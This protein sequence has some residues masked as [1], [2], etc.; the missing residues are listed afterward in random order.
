MSGTASQQTRA[1]QAHSIQAL[2]CEWASRQPLATQPAL[3]NVQQKAR[4]QLQALAFPDRKTEAWKYTGLAA[5]DQSSLWQDPAPAASARHADSIAVAADSIKVESAARIALNNGKADISISA[6]AQASVTIQRFTDLSEA[7][8]QKYL[9][10]LALDPR[11]QAHPFAQLCEATLDQGWLVVVK[12]RQ[13]LPQ[14]IVIEQWLDGN[15]TTF[16]TS[17]RVLVVIESGAEATLLQITDSPRDTGTVLANALVQVHVQ[18]NASLQHI[19]LQIADERCQQV[20]VTQ[21]NLNRDSRYQHYSIALGTALL[22]NDLHLLFTAPGADAQLNG[23][24]LSKHAQHVDNHLN[25]EHVSGRC[26]SVT[27]YKGLVTD[28]S[29]AVFNGRVHIHPQAQKTD[30]QLNNK[31]LLLSREAEIDTKPE[32]EI[33]ADDV[34]CAHGASIGQLDEKALF[35]FESR[36]IDKAT[37]EAMLSFGFINEIVDTLPVPGLADAVNKRLINYFR[38]VKQLE[39]LWQ[40]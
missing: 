11:W 14:P 2:A 31:N 20:Q 13:Q 9:P 26:Q 27:R 36:G 18:D 5:L 16:T 37:A 15:N 8:L 25:L 6:A 34:K 38:D 10:L 39:G 17:L 7:D 21:T 24:F 1:T 22:R 35:Y 28:Q 40:S 12:A 29:R 32:L 3:L 4:A 19:Q 30:A 23:A 33:Y